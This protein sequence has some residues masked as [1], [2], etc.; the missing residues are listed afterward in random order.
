MPTSVLLAVLAAAGLLALAPALVRRYDATERLV[1]ERALST[2]RVLSRA[3]RRR[4]TV[5]G[6]RPLN[7]PRLLVPRV[8]SASGPLPPPRRALTPVSA[9]P[10]ARRAAVAHRRVQRGPRAMYRRRRVLL[11][12][13]LLNLVEVCGITLVSPGFWVSF[14]VTGVLLVYYLA[15]LRTRALRDRRRRR[16]EA[17]YAA[18]IARRQAQVRREQLRR[19]AARREALAAQLAERDRA[20]REAARLN[21]LRGR[22]YDTRAS[23]Q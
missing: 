19:A 14:A 9:P 21:S 12:L 2:A 15:H 23:G 6:R 22:P 1:A 17:R 16:E 5:P 18:W 11:A 4:R 13:V 3:D 7:P 10:A 20:R 8:S